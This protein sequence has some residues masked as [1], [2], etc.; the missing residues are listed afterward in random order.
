MAP[1]LLV[2]DGPAPFVSLEELHTVV[3]KSDHYVRAE[4]EGT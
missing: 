2:T 1:Y 4:M 3:R